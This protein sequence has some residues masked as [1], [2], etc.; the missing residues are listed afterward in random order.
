MIQ[1]CLSWNF[2][3]CSGRHEEAN[4]EKERPN[5]LSATSAFL[6]LS[7]PIISQEVV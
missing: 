2:E 6:V 4:K 7:V 1:W 5:P 3:F